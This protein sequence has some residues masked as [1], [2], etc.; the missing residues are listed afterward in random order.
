MT[1]KYALLVRPHSPYSVSLS[2]VREIHVDVNGLGVFLSA[3]G[4]ACSEW[5]LE[6]V[7]VCAITYLLITT[8]AMYFTSENV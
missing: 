6:K 5:V 1:L 3:P 2:I 4:T 8:A 7:F